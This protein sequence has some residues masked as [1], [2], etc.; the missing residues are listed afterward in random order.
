MKVIYTFTV[1][2]VLVGIIIVAFIMK[3]TW[4]L[5]SA[6]FA[7]IG[8]YGAVIFFFL[9]LQQIFSTLNN[10]YWIPKIEA[11]ADRLPETSIQVV[12]YR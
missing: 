6:G 11:K 10:K 2:A 4:N 3:G 1:V 8:V 7:D 12:G 5:F 9:I